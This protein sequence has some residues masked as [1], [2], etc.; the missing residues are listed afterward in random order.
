MLETNSET[1]KKIHVKTNITFEDVISSIK[2]EDI[3]VNGRMGAILSRNNAIVRTTTKYNESAQ[4]MNETIMSIINIIKFEMK[5]LLGSSI[6][7]NNALAEIY[8]TRYKNM[9]YH[10]DQ[11]LDLNTNS[12]IALFSLYE[13]ENNR[14]LLVKKKIKGSI[15]VS[16][17]LT[18][19]SVV[20]FSTKENAAHLHK[21]VLDQKSKSES[22]WFGLTLRLSKTQVDFIDNHVLLPTGKRLKLALENQTKDFFKLRSNENKCEVF[23]YP[24]LDY[25]ISK[26]DLM[27]P[28]KLV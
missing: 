22:K 1:F 28:I 3:G 15:P 26:S 5:S 19:K 13:N 6:D 18:N 20:F 10:S 4:I 25:T 2:F 11:A 17:E 23:K 24:L 9:G 16:I 8:D 27:Q 21:I 14:N 7:F 12:Y